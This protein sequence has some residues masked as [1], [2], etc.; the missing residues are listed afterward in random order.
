MILQVYLGILIHKHSAYHGYPT[1]AHKPLP[2]FASAT[3]ALAPAQVDRWK[4]KGGKRCQDSNSNLSWI[5]SSESI[6]TNLNITYPELL[7]IY[8]TPQDSSKS[9]SFLSSSCMAS[10]CAA[11]SFVSRARRAPEDILGFF[12][13]NTQA[14]SPGSTN[15]QSAIEMQNLHVLS[16]SRYLTVPRHICTLL[17][18]MCAY[19]YLYIY[20]HMACI[21]TCIHK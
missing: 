8:Q 3:R 21:D 7:M 16:I 2:P 15:L 14:S 4:S 9:I 12:A 18:C 10:V 20:I 19:V 13:E 17:V 11:C 6:S 5:W 1:T